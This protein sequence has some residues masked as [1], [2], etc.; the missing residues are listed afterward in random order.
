[1]TDADW[2]TRAR[3]AER[4]V[5][6]FD[7]ALAAVAAEL[8]LDRVLQLIVD[9]VRTLSGAR[10][11]ALGLM[12]RGGTIETFITSGISAGARARIGALPTGHGLLGTLIREGRSIRVGDVRR[13]PRSAGV[14]PHHFEVRGFLGVPVLVRGRAVG[15]LY[16]ANRRDGRPF[17]AADQALVERFALHAG[18]AID[19]ARLLDE[20]Q[21]LAVMDERERIGRELHD[22]VIQRLYGVSLSLEDVPELVPEDP[23]DARRRVDD[24]IDALHGAI[25]EMRNFIYALRPVI[26]APDD[27]RRTLTGLGEETER[28]AEITVETRVDDVPLSSHAASELVAITRELLSNVTRH[29]GGTHATVRVSVAGDRVRLRVADDGHGFDPRGRRGSEQRGL[30]N[31]RDRATALGGRITIRSGSGTGTVV[32]V[33]VPAEPAPRPMT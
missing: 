26:P 1:M 25:I 30:A 27:L 28:R 14:P 13:D 17:S 4:R 33:S 9:Q 31:I 16:L 10:Y 12:A 18:I 15:N 7:R 5:A 19:N 21:R 23:V 2:R 3:R 32:T 6:A 22:S 11:A 29:S 24:A 8:D 20:V